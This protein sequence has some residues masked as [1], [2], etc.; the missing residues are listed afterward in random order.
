MTSHS[1]RL[2]GVVLKRNNFSEAD[3]I[4]T[5]FSL[6]RG[7]LPFLAK[8]IRRIKSRRSPHLELFNH[9]ELQIHPGKNFDL[10]TEAKIINSFDNIKVDLELSG[11]SF[12]LAEILDRILPEKE[13]HP[14]VFADLLSCLESINKLKGERAEA[15]KVVKEFVLRLLWEL[16]YLP[17]GQPPPISLT[18]FVETV[19]ERRIES[20]KFLE[21]I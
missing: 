12:Y 4:V 3:K 13:P 6:E 8:G 19:V 21:E 11:Y 1:E 5:I 20:K 16:G 15:E 18:D 14:E 10:I 17:S 7:K 9:V 2:L